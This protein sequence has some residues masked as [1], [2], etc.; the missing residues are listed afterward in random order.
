MADDRDARIARL[1]AELQEV[2]AA[3]ES[4]RAATGGLVRDNA[5]LHQ[6]VTAMADV[7]RAIASS[8]TSV[9]HVLTAIC[10]TAARLCQARN[11]VLLQIR[12]RDGQLAPRALFGPVPLVLE[13]DWAPTSGPLNFESALGSIVAPTSMPGRAFLEGRVIHVH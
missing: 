6:Q 5:A 3:H 9:D 13:D 11:G 10:E 7:L 1:E 12:A 2:R 8:A 4:D